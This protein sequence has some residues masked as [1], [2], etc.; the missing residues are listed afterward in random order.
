MRYTAAAMTNSSRAL[1]FVGAMVSLATFVSCRPGRTVKLA[2][3]A[4]AVLPA[5][6][7]ILVDDA[8]VQDIPPPAVDPACKCLTATVPVPDGPHTVKVVAYNQFGSSA[9][10]AVAVVK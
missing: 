4:P 10:S 3:D 9:P 6:Y 1:W 2:W 8:V 7:R 5:G